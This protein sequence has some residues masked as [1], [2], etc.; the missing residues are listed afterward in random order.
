MRK[1]FII[2]MHGV[3]AVGKTTNAL[4]LAQHLKIKYLSTSSIRHQKGWRGIQSISERHNVY[5]LLTKEIEDNVSQGKSLILD[6]TYSLRHWREMVYKICFAT[7]I[8]LYIIRCVCDDPVEIRKRMV[9]RMK[10]DPKPSPD[11]LDDNFHEY[12]VREKVR[13]DE[14][15][16]DN[17]YQPEKVFIISY[18]TKR[19]VINL[20][21]PTA[22]KNRGD[23]I[24]REILVFLKTAQKD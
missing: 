2:M 5:S 12:W 8:P 16:S 17:F 1:Q 6:A 20:I 14:L 23:K 21:L 15:L 7:G 22:N 9:Y 10:H 11:S 24:L 19:K 18:D 4:V 13:A 3:T